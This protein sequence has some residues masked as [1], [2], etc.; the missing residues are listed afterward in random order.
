MDA[1]GSGDRKMRGFGDLN[2]NILEHKKIL[3]DASPLSYTVKKFLDDHNPYNQKNWGD[4]HGYNMNTGAKIGSSYRVGENVDAA[5]EEL[6]KKFQAE[7]KSF[8][9]EKMKKLY[10]KGKDSFVIERSKSLGRGI[11]ARLSDLIRG[12]EKGEEFSISDMSEDSQRSYERSLE[13]YRAA[14]GLDKDEKG[15]TKIFRS[16][17]AG[18]VP[19][20]MVDY[21]KSG[22][23][24]AQYTRQSPTVQVAEDGGERQAGGQDAGNALGAY[25]QQTQNQ[26]GIFATM[27]QIHEQSW[28]DFTSKILGAYSRQSGKW[29]KFERDWER[30]MSEMRAEKKSSGKK[31]SKRR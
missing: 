18:Y 2:P 21:L 10:R 28:R 27:Y 25:M 12:Y 23:K 19:N 7:K 9:Y 4:R 5:A 30:F 26:L 22:K 15:A 1:L 13:K 11:G 3:E 29:S 17:I 24:Y 8:L 16:P 20:S 14:A 6:Y 31:K